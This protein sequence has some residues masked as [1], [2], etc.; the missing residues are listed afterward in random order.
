M[1]ICRHILILLIVIA[2]LGGAVQAQPSLQSAD[3]AGEMAAMDMVC[4]QMTGM[5]AV[6]DMPC[7]GITPECVKQMGC[8]TIPALAER[9]AANIVSVSYT[10]VVYALQT[11][12]A[13]GLSHKPDL[14]P[15]RAI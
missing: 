12:D 6:R 15:P 5:D 8:V 13:E 3:G 9:F 14:L 7:K 4:D 1:Y 2:S 10:R 11:S